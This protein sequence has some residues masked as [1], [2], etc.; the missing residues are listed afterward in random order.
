[1]PLTPATAPLETAA[2]EVATAQENKEAEKETAPTAEETEGG[3]ET[4]A[5]ATDP[6]APTA[7]SAVLKHGQ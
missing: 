5:A 4:R 6:D 2:V 7:E 1:M 3:T